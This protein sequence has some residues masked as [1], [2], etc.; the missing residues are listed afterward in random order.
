MDN[1]VAG[2]EE[3]E[4]NNDDQEVSNDSDPWYITAVNSLMQLKEEAEDALICDVARDTTTGL[5]KLNKTS[6]IYQGS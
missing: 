6:T 1:F 3:F 5:W 4:D 2:L